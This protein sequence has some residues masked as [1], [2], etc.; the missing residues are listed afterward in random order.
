MGQ[1]ELDGGRCSSRWSTST[2]D[3]WLSVDKSRPRVLGSLDLW[4]MPNGWRLWLTY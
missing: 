1:M 3:E 2:G 4:V